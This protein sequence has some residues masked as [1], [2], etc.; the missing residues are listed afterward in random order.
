METVD[1]QQRE[2]K[3][4]DF[5]KEK[6]AVGKWQPHPA[7]PV[8]DAQDPDKEVL[9]H[10]RLDPEDYGEYADDRMRGAWS[11]FFADRTWYLTH[12]KRTLDKM[13][14]SYLVV[15][16]VH[17]SDDPVFVESQT[18]G[19]AERIHAEMQKGFMVL[20]IAG[21]KSTP[22]S[23]PFPAL[24]FHGIHFNKFNTDRRPIRIR[25]SKV[26]V[27][28]MVIFGKQAQLTGRTLE[29]VTDYDGTGTDIGY[30]QP[31]RFAEDSSL[32]PTPARVLLATR[33]LLEQNLDMF[34]SQLTGEV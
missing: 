23:G 19:I 9:R 7:E 22:R 21:F 25:N 14:P 4:G 18:S 8:S 10:I 20:P 34:I 13:F 6:I 15:E 11:L 30:H 26:R 29:G 24:K 31:R 28:D 12:G 5:L 32:Q 2:F 17:G 3:L 16:W 1:N 27:V 33:E